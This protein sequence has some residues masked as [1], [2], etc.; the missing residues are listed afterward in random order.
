[1]AGLF[2]KR[3]LVIA[4]ALVALALAGAPITAQEAQAPL[5][6]LRLSRNIPGDSKPVVLYADDIAT[7]SENGTRVILLKGRVLVQHGVLTVRA[8]QA[9]AFIDEGRYRQTKI[10]RV[11][12][13]AEGEVQAEEGS[14]AQRGPRGLFDLSTR[15]E[16]KLKSYGRPV[17][18]QPVS[19]DPLFLRAQAE[20]AP[21]P[22]A[23]APAPGPP[24][25]GG[26]QRTNFQGMAPAPAPPTGVLQP[27]G[28]QEPGP[29]AGAGGS[30]PVPGS[31]APGPGMPALQP[32]L[33]LPGGGAPGPPRDAGGVPVPVPPV[34]PGQNRPQQQPRSA[35]PPGPVGILAPGPP[36]IGPPRTLTIRRR[37]LDFQVQSFPMPSGEQAV[38][39]TGGV[40]LTVSNDA[41]IGI[42]DI[43]ADRL[44][45]WT[46]G[47]SQQ[48]FRNM[49]TAQ[50][51]TARELEFYLAG[52]V[53]IRQQNIAKNQPLRILRA[54]E[55][56]YDVN[57]SVAVAT[58]ADL[59]ISQHRIPYPI[60]VRAEELLQ[61]SPDTFE[62]I[63]AVASSSKLSSDPGIQI[64]FR[65]ATLE[66]KRETRTS[67]F[68]R[69]V[70]SRQ[71]GQ[72]LEETDLFFK[73]RSVFLEV[74]DVPV[75]YLPYAAGRANQPFGPLQ[76]VNLGF[77]NIFGFQGGVTLDLYELLGIEKVQNT[78][79]RMNLDY[80]SKRGPGLGS[81]FNAAG[82]DLFGIPGFYGLTATAWGLHDTGTDNLGGGRGQ[83]DNHPEWRGWLSSRF[84][85]YD[86]PYGFSA[87][88]G[89]APE[90][91]HNF[92]EQYFKN[93]FD[94]D[95]NQETFLYV[96]QQQGNW[97]WT[98][99]DEIRI[100]NWVSETSWQPKVDGYLLGQSFFD[101]LTYNGHASAGY[102]LLRPAST[103]PE[104]TPGPPPPGPIT[105]VKD[106]TGRFDLWQELSLPFYLGP[107]K[108][109]P[110]GRVDL[111]YYTRDLLGDDRGRFY[112]GGGARAS[113][114]LTRLYPDI[115][116]E[117]FNINGINHKVVLSTNYY[118]AHSDTSFARLPQLDRLND[119]AT[120][121]ALRDITPQQPLINPAHGLFLQT[122]PTFNPQIFALRQLV[123]DRVDT[124]DSI[125]E[126]EFDVR[127][128][129]QTKR[130]Y[131]GMQHIVDWMTLDLSGTF[132]PNPTSDAFGGVSSTWGFLQYDYTWNIGDR[133]AF[134]STG[135]IDAVNVGANEWTVGLY[136]NRPD[137]T[138]FF[139]GFRDIDIL[140]SQAVTGAVT[141]V[142]SPK[143][144]VTGSTVYDFGTSQALS[145]S[146]TL[147]RMGSDVQISL[148]I[149]YNALQNNFGM[150]FQIIPN[151][152]PNAGRLPGF[153]PGAQLPGS[154]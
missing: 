85:W 19:N 4:G 83:F 7:W 48:M 27:A 54:E 97:A 90:S 8:Q 124:L 131:P 77:N 36:G 112:G 132:F 73:A 114:P 29:G 96:K 55:V 128:R 117:L 2:Q 25:P 120:D 5:Q 143:Y 111:T 13:Y 135:W 63:N 31:G 115:A 126:V 10:L 59:E 58:S 57:R 149:T 49:T 46:R 116:S 134:V 146:L 62:V 70:T 94:T 76:N 110:Y 69:T 11:D 14:T 153:S 24:A 105:T 6:P 137:R 142:F 125:Q 26:L 122:N 118:I 74:E 52:N 38:V 22:A 32:P 34:S 88:V 150:T 130:G 45:L 129:W 81:D 82:K 18:Q 103:L 133:T 9:A 41:R 21:K 60:H 93:R 138:N 154:R 106:D 51:E 123:Q 127:Q 100:R 139:I 44:V 1:M 78:T 43:E 33:P 101:L 108:V 66:N 20:R 23:P 148:G 145:N 53:E 67:I 152:V 39:V 12:L 3:W 99:L 107:V 71:T 87:Q 98:A 84:N 104:P 113:M 64:Y 37:S 35:T 79:W 141:Y 119:D 147:T 16:L 75:F 89:L 144:A 17:L 56:Y 136:L 109:A 95:F 92:Y 86:L 61:T 15:G 80:L 47:D 91:D 151:I 30:Q 42:L 72:P 140:Q 68:G 65:D 28:F 121:Q 40:I 50:G 102:G